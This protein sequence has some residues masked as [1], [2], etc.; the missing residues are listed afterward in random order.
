MHTGDIRDYLG[1]YVGIV[2]IMLILYILWG[3]A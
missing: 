3:G 1:W 2:A